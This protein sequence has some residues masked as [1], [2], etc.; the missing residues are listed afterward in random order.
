[1]TKINGYTLQ[2][3]FWS[4]HGKQTSMDAYH[5][6]IYFYL[7]ELCNRLR[8]KDQF[9]V[10]SAHTA[11]ELRISKKTYLKKFKELQ[12][13]GLVLVTQQAINEQMA[14]KITLATDEFQEWAKRKENKKYGQGTELNSMPG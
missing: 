2:K 11:G 3:F 6:A 4:V 8:W 13:F 10:P 9:R 12:H 5:I 14:T 7:A 1:M